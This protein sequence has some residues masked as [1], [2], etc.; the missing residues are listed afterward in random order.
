[1]GNIRYVSLCNLKFTSKMSDH[2]IRQ[3]SNLA[4]P[5]YIDKLPENNDQF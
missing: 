4:N 5:I 3:D 2:F 1:M